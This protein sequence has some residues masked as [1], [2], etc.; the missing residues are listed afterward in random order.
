MKNEEY[1]LLTEVQDI[2]QKRIERIRLL[3]SE[4]TLPVYLRTDRLFDE[5]RTLKGCHEL[6]DYCRAKLPIVFDGNHMYFN[7]FDVFDKKGDF[8]GV[9]LG[10]IHVCPET[11]KRVRFKSEDVYRLKKQY[12]HCDASEDDNNKLIPFK[13]FD[14][15]VYVANCKEKKMEESEIAYDLMRDHGKSKYSNKNDSMISALQIGIA[16]Y[17]S[18]KHHSKNEKDALE[19]RVWRDVKKHAP[20]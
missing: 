17:P 15:E 2:L 9:A 4:G 5:F 1:L 6:G 8:V 18:A 10:T 16:V 13:D 7:G 20:K 3:I 11:H 19:S 14:V 12:E